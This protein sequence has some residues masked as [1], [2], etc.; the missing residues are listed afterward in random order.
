MA[1]T[2]QVFVATMIAHEILVHRVHSVWIHMMDLDACAIQVNQ[3]AH[4]NNTP[5]VRVKMEAFVFNYQVWP[6]SFFFIDV[7]FLLINLGKPKVAIWAV[8]V[9]MAI[10]EINVIKVSG[11]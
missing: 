8:V 9:V 6:W 11:F 4:T 7:K 3:L 10:L 1:A 2:C 5:V